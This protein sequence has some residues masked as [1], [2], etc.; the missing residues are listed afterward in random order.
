AQSQHENIAKKIDHNQKFVD[1]FGA[2]ASKA[3]QAQ[4]KQKAVDRLKSMQDSIE[5]EKGQQAP[6]ILIPMGPPS[7]KNVIQIQDLTVGYATPL[8]KKVKLPVMRGQKIAIVGANGIGKS[9]ILKTLVGE[10]APLSGTIKFGDNVKVGYYAQSQ[11]DQLNLD[12]SA[13]DNVLNANGLLTEGEV[14]KI[15]GSLLFKDQDIRKSISVMSGG[16]KSRVGLACMIAKRANTLLMDEPTNHLDLVTQENLAHALSTY[17]GT[18]IFV[19]HDR[20]FINAIAT[21][22]L[23]VKSN[24]DHLLIEGNLDAF[25]EDAKRLNFNLM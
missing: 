25:F 7:V 13:Y 10:I 21:H 23:G 24:G 18:L 11:L 8:I 4:S 12:A 20:R 5:V 3:R 6:Q 17:P 15:L 2:K 14:R 19:S 16:E 1:R 9:T 22:V